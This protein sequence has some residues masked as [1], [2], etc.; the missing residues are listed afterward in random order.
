ARK[1]LQVLIPLVLVIIFAILYFT[2][3]SAIEAGLV[4]LS[5]PFALIGGVYLMWLYGFNW[6][7]A[8]WVGF[9][10]L[11]GV[12]VQ[13]GVVMVLYLHEALD[14][15][16]LDGRVTVQEIFEATVEGALLRVR[17]KVMTVATTV[18]GLI[19]LLWATG[20]GSDVMKPI[21]V[22]LIGGMVT[23]TIHVLLVT[24]IIFFIV[25]R[26]EL[27]RGRLKLSGLRATEEL[28]E[29]DDTPQTDPR[30]V[31]VEN[32]R[33]E[34]EPLAAIDRQPG[35]PRKKMIAI[36]AIAAS[37]AAVVFAGV[38]LLRR[39]E[40]GVLDS[41][42]AGGVTVTIA[43]DGRDSWE[44]VFADAAS[45]EPVAVSGVSAEAVM[46][47]MGS[48]PQ[49]TEPLTI[50][51]RDAE[52]YR[53][54]GNLMNGTWQIRIRFNGPAGPTQALVEVNAS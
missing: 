45:K 9:I 13:T 23:S 37:V 11:Y 41:A 5:V 17:P 47:A 44:L 30:L 24:P 4:M 51:K 52:R 27:K 6:S 38:M 8:V 53:A 43:A 40:R 32:V 20:A 35:R 16:M 36:A 34:E 1:R 29:T 10:A 2:L 14:R 26:H 7:V 33:E 50:E 54:R 42:T 46:P 28:Q 12:A 18:L 19:P 22:P 49:M 48:M 39:S 31:T 3:H 15:K 25:K 21:A